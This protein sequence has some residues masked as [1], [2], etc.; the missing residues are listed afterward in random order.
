MFQSSPT[1]RGGRYGKLVKEGICQILSFNPRPPLEVGATMTVRMT[2]IVTIMFQSSPT[3]RG[4][5][6]AT[7]CWPQSLKSSFQSSPTPRG[8]RYWLQKR[9]NTTN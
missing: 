8:G 6:Y 1:P 3:P 4:G 2:V 5:R 7:R 9:P